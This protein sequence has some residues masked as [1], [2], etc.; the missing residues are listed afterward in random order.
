MGEGNNL[1]LTENIRLKMHWGKKKSDFLFMYV[2]I[3]CTRMVQ[4]QKLLTYVLSEIFMFV[5]LF[6]GE[7]VAL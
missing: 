2:F 1:K 3:F 4:M 6:L 7:N 5:C